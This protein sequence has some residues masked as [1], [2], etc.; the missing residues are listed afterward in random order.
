[1]ILY[2]SGDMHAIVGEAIIEKILNEPID[3]LIKHTI[4]EVPE[5]EENLRKS[6]AGHVIGHAIK[7]RNPLRYETPLTLA[8]IRSQI[9]QFNPPR[10]FIT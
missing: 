10:D 6:F 5:T 4:K 8:T 7:V 2:A 1:M 9:P 3:L